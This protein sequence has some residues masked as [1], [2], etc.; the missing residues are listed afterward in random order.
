MTQPVIIIRPH[1]VAPLAAGNPP[2]A[3]AAP[4]TIPGF[5]DMSFAQRRLAQ[6]QLAGKVR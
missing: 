1:P 6:D 2:P 3:P 5:K 4:G